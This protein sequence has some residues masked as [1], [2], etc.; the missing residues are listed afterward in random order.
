MRSEQE[1]A[2]GE[3]RKWFAVGEQ[4][5]AQRFIGYAS[6]VGQTTARS[7]EIVETEI[8]IKCEQ[9]AIECEQRASESGRSECDFAV[10]IATWRRHHDV[11]F[12]NE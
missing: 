5:K 2:Q 10:A 12:I 9:H 3:R 1:R 4:T 8:S 6:G 7:E 11:S